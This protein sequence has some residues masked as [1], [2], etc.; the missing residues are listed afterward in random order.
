MTALR[1]G[2]IAL[3]VIAL[4]RFTKWLVVEEMRLRELGAIEL[5]PGFLSFRMAWNRGINFGILASDSPLARWGLALMAVAV[6]VGV[7]VWAARRGEPLFT[8]GAGALV[9]GALGN[10]WDRMTYGA[11]AD[12]L[13][14]TCCGIANPYAFNVADV[15][16][17]GGAFL[18]LVAPARDESRA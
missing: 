7:A 2:L 3:G 8:I 4:D 14:V 12:F 18:L 6:S 15:A 9:G 17:F 13:N 10:A 1:L 5:W 16:I 11:V